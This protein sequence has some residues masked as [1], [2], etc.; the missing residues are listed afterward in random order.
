MKNGSL[1]SDD[2]TPDFL[3]SAA[4]VACVAQ[5]RR[6]GYRFRLRGALRATART[7]IK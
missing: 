1:D 5:A 3:I 6:S 4:A 7:D 2:L